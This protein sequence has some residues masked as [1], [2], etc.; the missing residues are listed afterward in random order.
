[1]CTVGS[2]YPQNLETCVSPK[3][4]SKAIDSPTPTHIHSERTHLLRGTR[5]G[6]RKAVTHSGG[7]Y[8]TK[9]NKNIAKKNVNA[10]FEIQLSQMAVPTAHALSARGRSDRHAAH[11]YAH[12]QVGE[13]QQDAVHARYTKSDAELMLAK[14]RCRPRALYK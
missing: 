7:I 5:R 1:M 6:R 14:Y 8:K 13:W 10:Q 11:A 4:S 2:D 9:Q 3:R 12:S